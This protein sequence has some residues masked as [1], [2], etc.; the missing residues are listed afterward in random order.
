MKTTTGDEYD[1]VREQQFVDRWMMEYE[2]ERLRLYPPSPADSGS[3]VSPPPK[4][5][6]RFN[7]MGDFDEN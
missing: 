2:R 7:D 4:H 6:G 5:E 1:W 3:W